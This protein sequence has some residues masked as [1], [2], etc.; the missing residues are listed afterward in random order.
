MD[1]LAHLVRLEDDDGV[2]ALPQ[3]WCRQ[4][5]CLLGT[6]LI[7][8]AEV[9]IV[10]KH[11]TLRPA[12]ERDEGVLGLVH[13]QRGAEQF[14]PVEF[15]RV[16]ADPGV[17]V[18][19]GV[20]EGAVEVEAKRLQT[21]NNI[22]IKMDV[23]VN[24]LAVVLHFMA[25]LLTA[26]VGHQNVVI[27]WHIGHLVASFDVVGGMVLFSLAHRVDGHTVE[28]NVSFVFHLSCNKQ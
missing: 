4:V 2:V 21:A 25:N 12:I 24:A 17:H 1:R 8:A 6:N 15:A 23:S 9:E 13:M 11:H 20:E 19:D 28:Q 27:V 3:Q 22:I 26:Q 14:G 16:E 10:D 18:I 5:E 7:V